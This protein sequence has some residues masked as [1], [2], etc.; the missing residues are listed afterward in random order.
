MHAHSTCPQVTE[1]VLQHGGS[2]NITR[3]NRPRKVIELRGRQLLMRG[4]QPSGP[5]AHV[6]G[7]RQSMIMRMTDGGR[8]VQ[9]VQQ[10][11]RT[12]GRCIQL[13]V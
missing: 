8:L 2:F 6:D 12:L 10:R 7:G 13:H 9:Q 3:D 4:P 11:A 5:P 1:V